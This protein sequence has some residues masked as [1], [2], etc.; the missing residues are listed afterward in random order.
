MYKANIILL[1][2]KLKKKKIIFYPRSSVLLT[3]WKIVLQ[4][5]IA[6]I[7]PAS[8][9]VRV[10]DHGYTLYVG[11]SAHVDGNCDLVDQSGT[12]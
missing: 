8:G 3:L 9:H 12:E 2:H 4:R 5:W 1:H 10:L 7:N 6:W 11:H